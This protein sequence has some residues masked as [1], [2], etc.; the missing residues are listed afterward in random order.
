MIIPFFILIIACNKSN[1]TL[2]ESP[3]KIHI[4]WI[5]PLSGNAKVLGE[6]NLKSIQ[7]VIK[8]YN[9]TKEKNEPQIILTEADD[10]Y[11]AVLTKDVFLKLREK[12]KPH[13]VFLNTYDAL[14]QHAHL[15]ARD[16]IIIINPIDN[17]LK[18]A[19]LNDNVFLIAK[20]TEQLSS[21]VGYDLINDARNN[22]A[23]LYYNND[24]FM[25]TVASEI[26]N[27]LSKNGRTA[28]LYPYSK[29][30]NNFE[31]VLSIDTVKT[32]DAVVLLGYDEMENAVKYLKNT[33]KDIHF[34][35][36]NTAMQ[37]LDKPE[38]VDLI[39]GMKI[40]HFTTLDGNSILANEFIDNFQKE[41]NRSPYVDWIA[42]QAYDSIGLVLRT[43]KEMSNSDTTKKNNWASQFKFHLKAGKLYHG[44]SGDI[45]INIDGTASGI[46]LGHYQIINGEAKRLL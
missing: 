39:D 32:L 8:N 30:I 31:S 22:T 24:S 15:V 46:T 13:I 12:I 26:R 25:P 42:F 2:S 7:M 4:F 6:D 18:L 45:I 23:I 14:I 38:L 37:L 41:Y 5:G 21:V 17:D 28:S 34:Y 36:V 44:T 40:A 35:S 3:D 1:E 43:I 27:M 10:Q 11:D 29:E 33:N 19:G 20:R 16:D 9:R